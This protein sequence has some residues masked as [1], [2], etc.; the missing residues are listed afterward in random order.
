MSTDGVR[1][2]VIATG[3]DRLATLF[4]EAAQE[5]QPTHTPPSPVTRPQDCDCGANQ[6]I[7]VAHWE[8]CAS[9]NRG[10]S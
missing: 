1:L 4:Q 9:R 6:L 10:R 5:A 3:W 7:S 2:Q 8:R